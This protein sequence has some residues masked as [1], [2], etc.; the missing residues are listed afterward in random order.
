MPA[1]S[2]EVLPVRS[3]T[4]VVQVR[5]AV[6]ALTAQLGFSLIDQT[7]VVTAASELARNT[8]I[9]GGGGRMVLTTVE[10]PPRRGLRMEFHD[11]GP[12][13]ADVEQALRDGFTSGSGLGLG[14]GGSRRLMD[15]FEIESAVGQGTRIVAT[16]WK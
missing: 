12:G 1:P 11:T 6:R 15:E 4:D 9:Y 13:I 10:R 8:L 16:K 7:K 3:S 5:Q 2:D 14:L